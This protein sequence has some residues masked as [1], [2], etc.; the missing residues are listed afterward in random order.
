MATQ[1]YHSADHVG[2]TMIVMMI[3]NQMQHRFFIAKEKL[4]RSS[5]NAVIPKLQHRFV[6][7]TWYH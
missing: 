3:E 5:I 2:N 1:P 6:V 7:W 4:D